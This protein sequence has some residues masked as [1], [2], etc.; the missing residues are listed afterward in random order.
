LIILRAQHKVTS[1]TIVLGIFLSLFCLSVTAQAAPAGCTIVGH[2][3]KGM[4]CIQATGSNPFFQRQCIAPRHLQCVETTV[5]CCPAGITVPLPPTS[6]PLITPKPSKRQPPIITRGPTVALPAPGQKGFSDVERW[7]KHL[8]QLDQLCAKLCNSNIVDFGN[9]CHADS[10]KITDWDC[11]APRPFAPHTHGDV[12]ECKCPYCPHQL[13][14]PPP[15]WNPWGKYNH[16][17][18]PYESD[19]SVE[20]EN[21]DKQ[22]IRRKK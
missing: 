14:P 9:C 19:H 18:T 7:D 11:P 21:L 17:E 15:V 8:H 12:C 3:Q 5:Y 22:N 20:E 2:I 4:S 16:E 13:P 1:L 6:D 10:I